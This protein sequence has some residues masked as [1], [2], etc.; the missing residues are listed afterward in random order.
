MLLLGPTYGFSVVVVVL[1][2][3][4]LVVLVVVVVVVVFVRTDVSLRRKLASLLSEYEAIKDILKRR[5][6]CDSSN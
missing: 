6:S 4:L 2:V 1:L 5:E 3:G